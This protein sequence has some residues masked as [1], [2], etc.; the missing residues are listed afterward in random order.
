MENYNFEDKFQIVPRAMAPVE[1]GDILVIGG[2]GAYCS[3]MSLGNYNSHFI[4]AEYLYTKE[5]K[6]VKIR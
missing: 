2:A 1:V 5:G 6:I 3:G 4:P